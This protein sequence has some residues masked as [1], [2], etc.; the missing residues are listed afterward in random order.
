[1]IAEVSLGDAGT[2]D[3][4]GDVVLFAKL[5]LEIRQCGKSSYTRVQ[6]SRSFALGLSFQR[7]LAGML[8]QYILY[9]AIK[10]L[11]SKVLNILL[12]EYHS[13]GYVSY[14]FLVAWLSC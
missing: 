9:Y 10:F 3:V 12:A 13:V 5:V 11:L 8:E 7:I 2:R 4:V 6:N 1:M 14:V